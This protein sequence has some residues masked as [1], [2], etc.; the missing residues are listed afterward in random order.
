MGSP[1]LYRV[2][3]YTKTG[4]VLNNDSRM[5]LFENSGE[6]QSSPVQ[7]LGYDGTHMHHWIFCQTAL[8]ADLSSD[9][10]AVIILEGSTN[11]VDWYHLQESNVNTEDRSV[12]Q[13]DARALSG[14]TYPYTRLR[15]ANLGSGTITLDIMSFRNVDVRR[16]DTVMP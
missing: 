1:Y 5:D 10:D 14:M 12:I 3:T 9:A 13:T 15:C 6:D 11:K 7:K 2:E 16:T 4:L 8:T